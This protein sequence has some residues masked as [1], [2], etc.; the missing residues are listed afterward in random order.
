MSLRQL[1][2]RIE[3]LER[4]EAKSP[5]PV[6][7]ARARWEELRL[8]EW[9]QTNRPNEVEKPLTEKEEAELEELMHRFDPLEPAIKAWEEAVARETDRV[10]SSRRKRPRPNELA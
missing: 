9:K 1:R 4:L 3:R 6:N 2:T 10:W 5:K 8:R 7:A